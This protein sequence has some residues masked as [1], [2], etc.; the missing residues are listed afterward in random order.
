MN[1]RTKIK[2]RIMKYEINL[3]YLAEIRMQKITIKAK[4]KVNLRVFKTHLYRNDKKPLIYCYY[5]LDWDQ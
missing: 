5:Y 2:T 1:L 4:V 3:T